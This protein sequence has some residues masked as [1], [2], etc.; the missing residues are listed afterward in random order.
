MYSIIGRACNRDSSDSFTTCVLE[1]TG[2]S[3]RYHCQK[4]ATTDQGRALVRKLQ[5]HLEW[6][7]QDAM[8]ERVM[9]SH[10]STWPPKALPDD[11]RLGAR[12]NP[13][14]VVVLNKMWVD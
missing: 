3:H 12:D 10:W 11:Q 6:A 1:L 8:I 14:L 13:L 7:Q 5:Q 9:P 2:I 4:S